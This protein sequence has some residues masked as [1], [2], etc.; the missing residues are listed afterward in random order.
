MKILITGANGFIGSQLSSLLAAQGH[1]LLLACRSKKHTSL[2]SVL[3]GN[4]DSFDNWDNCLADIDVV[5]HLAACVHQMGDQT[6]INYQRTNI[7]AS[8]RLAA[9]ARR[10]GV[11]RF[12]F[13][14]TIKVNGEQT[15]HGKCFS[16]LDVPAPTD[17]YSESKLQAELALKEIS[18]NSAMELVIIRPPLVYGPGVKANFLRLVELAQGGMPLPFAGLRNYRDM[19]SVDN[20]CDLIAHCID[21]PEAT[22]KTLLVSDGVAYSTADIVTA[23]RELSG[24]PQRIFYFPP[25]VLKLLL[26]L[27]GKKAMAD[28]LFGSLQVDLSATTD[29]VG[30]TP[31]YTLKQTLTKMLH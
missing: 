20:L 6:E 31:K 4:I 26:G 11:K 17:A 16:S 18:S 19:V 28:R 9:S 30:W 21:K 12:I 1:S 23:V 25:V 29:M 5:I 7:D 27:M 3:I 13:L 24:L 14:S 15:H 22:G 10:C 2:P 8:V